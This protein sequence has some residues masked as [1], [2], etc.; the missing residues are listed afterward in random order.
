MKTTFQL[1]RAD[2]Q[3]IWTGQYGQLMGASI[4]LRH[5]PT[6]IEVTGEIPQVHRTKPSLRSAE[7]VLRQQLM[8]DLAAAVAKHLRIPGR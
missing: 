7:D 3:E 5:A 8:K 2:V 6:K 4:T 1:Q